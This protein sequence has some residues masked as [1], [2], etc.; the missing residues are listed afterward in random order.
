MAWLLFI[1]DCKKPNISEL[2]D[3]LGSSFFGETWNFLT[4]SPPA[5]RFYWPATQ[6]IIGSTALLGLEDVLSSAGLRSVEVSCKSCVETG[7]GGQ[8][9]ESGEVGAGANL[10]WRSARGRELSGH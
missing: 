5:R 7:T 10:S 6:D 1:E 8:S 9:G 2:Y 3:A 4:G